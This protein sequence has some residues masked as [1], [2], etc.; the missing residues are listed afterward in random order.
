MNNQRFLLEFC[1]DND[2]IE[3]SQELRDYLSASYK[4]IVFDEIVS[5]SKL[6]AH[7]KLDVNAYITV[8]GG[9]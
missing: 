3:M 2:V 5:A 1:K 6:I 7:Q 4:G 9:K 8:N